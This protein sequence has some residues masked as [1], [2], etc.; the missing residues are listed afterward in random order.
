MTLPEPRQAQPCLPTYRERNQRADEALPILNPLAIS[1]TQN[2]PVL[3]LRPSLGIKTQ[4][5]RPPDTPSL[6]TRG[7]LREKIG[8]RRAL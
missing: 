6:K 3:A 7:G 2:D 1:P 4:S 5:W 8:A